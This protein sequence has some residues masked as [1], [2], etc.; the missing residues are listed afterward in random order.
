MRS[1]N[2]LA[3]ELVRKVM[4]YLQGE[5]LPVALTNTRS[6]M[7][8]RSIH[9]D[10]T[11]CAQRKSAYLSS[12]ALTM[13]VLNH[14]MVEVDMKLMNLTAKYGYLESVKI[15]RARDPPCPWNWMTCQYSALP[16]QRRS[17]YLRSGELTTY[18]LAHDMTSVDSNLMC[19]AAKCGY[20]DCVKILRTLDPP[21]PLDDP[22]CPLDEDTCH[23]AAEGGH[24][25]VLQ[26][27]RSQDP[28]CPWDEWT[29]SDAAGGGHL[30]V[31]QWARSQDLPCRWDESTC[32]DA[33]KGGHLDVLRW[34]RSQDPPCL[35]DKYTCRYAAGGGHLDVLQ[36]A[37]SQDPPCPWHERT[38]R[39][40]EKCC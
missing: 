15:L 11:L 26:W 34:L 1:L 14:G 10:R 6:L 13:F 7:I 31:L 33:A 28:P 12:G 32:S 30:H 5:E 36:W 16:M 29:C 9:E 17:A 8:A 19:I 39:N 38:W 4:G 18:L 24:L 40:V 27:A 20:L 35:W 25:N 23:A 22:P 37:R 3:T 2:V 21:C